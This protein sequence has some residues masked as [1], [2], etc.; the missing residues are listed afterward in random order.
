MPASELASIERGISDLIVD[1]AVTDLQEAFPDFSLIRGG[2]MQE[3]P[4]KNQEGTYILV[5]IN[6]PKDPKA[7]NDGVVSARR[8]DSPGQIWVPSYEIG[9]GEMWYRRFTTEFGYYATKQKDDRSEARMSAQWVKA[10]IEWTLRR[11]QRI[12][13]LIDS[14]GEIAKQVRLYSSYAIEGGGPPASFI[15]RG[16][17]LWMV[18]TNAELDL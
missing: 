16:E 10:K 7:W 11:S 17:V 18:L 6:D 14:F 3:N 1:A 2:R 13:T 5:H 8:G 9:G 4:L 12:P 15:W